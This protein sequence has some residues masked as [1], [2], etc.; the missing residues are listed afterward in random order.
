MPED[1]IIEKQNEANV[2]P[3]LQGD[4]CTEALSRVLASQAFAKSA[5]LSSFLRYICTASLEG[6]ASLLRE[7][8]IG[9]EV[10]GRPEHFN[11]A[12]DTIV[13]TTARLLRQRLAQYYEVEGNADELRIAIPLGAYVPVFVSRARAPAADADIDRADSDETAPVNSLNDE[14]EAPAADSSREPKFRLQ[15]QATILWLRKR[16]MLVGA[17]TILAAV[18]G[19][20][21]V[22]SWSSL[23]AGTASHSST[24]VFW[25]TLFS[26]DRDTLLVTADTGL[27]MYR[28]ETHR[29][30]ALEDYIAKRLGADE[31]SIGAD[32]VARFRQR[33]YTAMSSVMLAAELG[34]LASVAPQRFRVRFARDLLLGD[35][36]RSNAIIVGV[37]QS[38]PW[39]GLFRNQLNFHI[40]WDQVSGKFLIRNDRP[41]AA[42]KASYEFSKD[43]P[44]KRGF[45]SIAYT[46]SLGGDGHTLLI[47]GTT[48]AGTEAAIEFLL[49]PAYMEPLLKQA[50]LPDGSVA[51]FEVLLQCVLQGDGNTDIQVLG[52]RTKR[53]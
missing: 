13:R 43:D 31:E 25:S 2:L 33:R 15:L 36:K 37:E 44:G 39:W 3:R 17:A 21:G 1:E 30:V 40:D 52:L 48:S 11:P 4:V 35:L 16:N 12:E 41:L 10:F 45:A 26:A 8:H 7:Q 27:V 28:L 24:D 22:A 42:E 20:A 53:S 38:N 6:K 47:G 46:R 49:N 34:K 18:L 50:R 9:V 14:V 5:R 51:G 23:F 19:L 32:N 29:E